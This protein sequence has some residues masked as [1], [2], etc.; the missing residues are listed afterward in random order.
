M[1]FARDAR[2]GKRLRAP[3]VEGPR[4]GECDASSGGCELRN[5]CNPIT[6][7]IQLTNMFVCVCCHKTHLCD[8]RHDCHIVAT[9]EGSVCAKTGFV[10]ESVLSGGRAPTAEPVS[11]PNIDTVNV[12]NIILSYVYGYLLKN[13]EHYSDVLRE[14]M[15]DG[16][17]KDHVESSV[18]FTFNR[19]FRQTNSV[20]KIPLST[21]GQLFIQ[22]IIGVHAKATK[23][24]STVI[25]VSRRK[26]EDS[27]LKQMRLEYGNAPGVRPGL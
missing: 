12:V 15:D 10:Y 20:H 1:P 21:I 2:T 7:D 11:E 22:L 19:V 27:L 18:Y 5:L 4:S 3:P 8:M 26:R 25:K 14:V 9:Q 6:R 13:A 17:F 24:D 16:R 23:Y